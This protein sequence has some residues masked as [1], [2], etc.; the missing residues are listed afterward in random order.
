MPRRLLLL[1]LDPF[2]PAPAPRITPQLLLP[3]PDSRVAIP[4]GD[5]PVEGV[6]ASLLLEGIPIRSSRLIEGN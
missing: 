2:A 3:L 5:E 6:L 4:L 1:D